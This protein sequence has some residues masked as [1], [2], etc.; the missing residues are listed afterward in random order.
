MA[1]IYRD[2]RS[3]SDETSL[4]SA[5]TNSMNDSLVSSHD[6]VQARDLLRPSLESFD[7]AIEVADSNSELTGELLALVNKMS[8]NPHPLVSDCIQGAE[9]YIN[10]GN[11]SSPRTN[12][13]Y[14]Q[15]AIHYLQSANMIEGFSLDDHL[16]Q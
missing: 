2:Q 14:Y 3:S 13:N 15:K 11:V 16:K 4:P 7:R 9:A 1:R 5:R 6:Y 8:N 10:F 12:D